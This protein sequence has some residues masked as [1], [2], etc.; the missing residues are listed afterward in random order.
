MLGQNLEFGNWIEDFE[1]VEA[2]DNSHQKRT[3]VKILRGKS[4]LS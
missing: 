4:P 3:I 1:D 2:I